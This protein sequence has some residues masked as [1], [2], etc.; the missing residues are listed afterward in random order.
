MLSYQYAIIRQR[1]EALELQITDAHTIN[2][3]L[4]NL[5]IAFPGFGASA[6]KLPG[7][8]PYHWRLYGLGADIADAWAL[9]REHLH[10]QGWTLLDDQPPSDQN[11]TRTM[12]F[13]LLEESEKMAYRIG[14][15]I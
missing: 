3:L 14:D 15:M 1:G 2:Q 8:A 11:L 10:M 13:G 4:D 12:C 5:A 6:S 7:D 9:I